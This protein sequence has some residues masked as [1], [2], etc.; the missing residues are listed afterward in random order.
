MFLVSRTSPTPQ[1]VI[2][3]CTTTLNLFAGEAM[4][5]V[6]LLVCLLT[7]VLSRV[8]ASH[9]H[10]A[11]PVMTSDDTSSLTVAPDIPTIQTLRQMIA[12]IEKNVS[13][14][15][16]FQN[17]YDPNVPAALQYNE[18]FW[19]IHLGTSSVFAS[20]IDMCLHVLG[21]Q[22]GKYFDDISCAAVAGMHFIG[23]FRR[24]EQPGS[25]AFKDLFLRSL[26]HIIVHSNPRPYR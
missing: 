14:L 17:K 24:L 12:R 18:G 15:K 10:D 4:L 11:T 21:N 8:S 16:E 3:G 26:P 23:V 2:G 5:A 13:F 25:A 9:D 7:T 19:D 22:L 1:R 6:L 20:R